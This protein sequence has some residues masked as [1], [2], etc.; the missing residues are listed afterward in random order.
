[1]H[2]ILQVNNHLQLPEEEQILFVLWSFEITK[3]FVIR[4]K[5]NGIGR[6]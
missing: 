3:Y 2:H 6:E 1:M 4:F 5:K